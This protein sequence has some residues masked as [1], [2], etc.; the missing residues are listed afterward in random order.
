MVNNRLGQGICCD[1]HP[2]RQL[3]DKTVTKDTGDAAQDKLELEEES[4]K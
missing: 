3:T 2:Q 1:E 4:I